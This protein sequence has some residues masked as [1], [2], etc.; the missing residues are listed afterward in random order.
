[1]LDST[2]IKLFLI[3]RSIYGYKVN[4]TKYKNL[5]N[6]IITKKR[7][8]ENL[9]DIL[10]IYIGRFNTINGEIYIDIAKK[11]YKRLHKRTPNEEEILNL[12]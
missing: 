2:N 7:F 8:N 5:V 4:D 3:N 6:I 12:I 10:K 1:M 11:Y 9:D